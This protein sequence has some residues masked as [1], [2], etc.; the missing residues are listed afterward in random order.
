M[1]RTHQC[2]CLYPRCSDLTRGGVHALDRTWRHA[3]AEHVYSASATLA[4][5]HQPTRLPP[6]H[7]LLCHA[8]YHRRGSW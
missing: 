6:P 8:C 3:F 1:R 4:L 2:S 5:R 7:T